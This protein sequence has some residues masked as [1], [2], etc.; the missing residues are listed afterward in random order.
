VLFGEPSGIVG[1]LQTW[2]TQGTSIGSLGQ[3]IVVTLEEALIGFLIGTTLGIVSGIALGRIKLLAEVFGPFIKVLNS[4]PR[5]VLGSVFVIMFGLGLES[6]VLLVIVL[7]FFGVFFNAFQGTREVDRNLIANAAIL[8]ASKWQITRQV[9]LP[10]A[11]TWIIASLHVAFGF[12]LIGAIVGE[13]IGSQQ[14][15]GNLIRAAQGTFDANGVWAA[16]VIMAVVALL[17]E[18]LITRLEKRLLRWRP[19]QLSGPDL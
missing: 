12:A 18:Y 4:I 9:V 6:K 7:V 11:F 16:M 1:R 17:A 8:G 15:L 10:S 2:I 19:T 13:F 3:Q 5:I 14:G